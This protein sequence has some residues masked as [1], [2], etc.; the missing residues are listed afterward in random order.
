MK[1]YYK[2]R[3]L[4]AAVRTDPDFI[5]IIW[6]IRTIEEALKG[7]ALEE[8]IGDPTLNLGYNSSR[9][10]FFPRICKSQQLLL[11]LCG[12]WAGGKRDV[13][14]I[15]HTAVYCSWCRVTLFSYGSDA[16][17]RAKDDHRPF[18]ISEQSASNISDPN[19]DTAERS[20][21]EFFSFVL[22]LLVVFCLVWW[23]FFFC[24]QRQPASPSI[25]ICI[26]FFNIGK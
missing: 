18:S 16:V 23:G 15:H 14:R 13:A 11:L 12:C 7:K 25:F 26:L 21:L 10:I 1:D 24:F 2:C 4:T 9:P 6:A 19:F 22:L 3:G 8:P 5:G 20:I 17:V